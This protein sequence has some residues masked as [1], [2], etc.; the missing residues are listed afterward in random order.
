M[1]NRG[2]TKAFDHEARLTGSGRYVSIT[3]IFHDKKTGK[4]AAGQRLQEE[5]G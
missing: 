3:D 2:E 1:V 4:P 5:N